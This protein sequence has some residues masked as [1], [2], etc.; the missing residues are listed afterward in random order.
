MAIF[1]FLKN[2]FNF[3]SLVFIENELTN[4][5]FHLRNTKGAMPKGQRG[6]PKGQRGAATL[7]LGHC[8]DSQPLTER[9]S[10]KSTD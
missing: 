5:Y 7:Y 10:D 4:M 1:L 2:K 9:K 3:I 8:L 6:A